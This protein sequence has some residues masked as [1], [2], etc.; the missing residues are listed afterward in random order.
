M[1]VARAMR[2]AAGL[3]LVAASGWLCAQAYP[4]AGHSELA[5]VSLVPFLL[6]LRGSTPVTAAGFGALWMLCFAWG[7]NDWFPRAVARYLDQPLSVGFVFFLCVTLG[8]AAPASMGF[9]LHYRRWGRAASLAAV[10]SAP[11]AWVAGEFARAQLLGDPWGLLGYSQAARPEWIQIADITGV[12]GVSF[13]VMLVNAAVAELLIATGSGALTGSFVAG[14]LAMVVIAPALTLAYGQRGLDATARAAAGHGLDVVVVQGNLDLEAQWR[15]TMHETNLRAYLGLTEAALAAAPADLVVWP[16]NAVTFFFDDAVALRAQIAATLSAR[17]AGLVTGGPHLVRGAAATFF[18]SAFLL[19]ADGAIR[20]R[21][22]KQRL[23]PFGE[24]QPLTRLGLVASR[25][26]RVREFSPGPEVATTLAWNGAQFG[27]VICNEAMFP[28]PSRERVAAGAQALIALTNDSWVAERKF[29]AQAFD[30]A[31]LRAVEQRRWL[32]RASTSGP[33]GI[34]DSAGRVVART[35]HAEAAFLRGRVGLQTG[36]TIYA[37]VGDAF[38]WVCV[39][40][41]FV[42][43]WRRRGRGRTPA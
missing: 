20:A 10:L 19:G 17:G 21:Y 2:N 14:C 35:K 29:A 16:E 37:A 9:A 8:S 32:I 40:G 34:V 24:F 4:D 41:A 1:I 6:C 3:L 12:Y 18:N 25:F 36:T 5:W 22:D 42:E 38:A 28:E 39:C 26:E 30:K 11:A 33:S 23:L 31:V 27:I 43:T 15:Q 13:V 7:I